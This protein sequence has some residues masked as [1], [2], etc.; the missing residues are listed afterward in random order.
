MPAEWS[1]EALADLEDICAYIARDNPE[2]AE[3]WIDKL[4]RKADK[5]SANPRAGRV[6]PEIEDPDIR[7][8]FLKSYRLIY[9][10]ER[11]RVIVLT[12]LEGHR[13]LRASRL[14]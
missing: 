11:E 10:V 4:I 13:R 3:D 8:V 14:R 5:A 1:P 12:V 2:A 9:R 7:E 6:V